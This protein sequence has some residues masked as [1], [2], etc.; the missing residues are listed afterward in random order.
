MEIAATTDGFFYDATVPQVTLCPTTCTTAENNLTANIQVTYSCD[1]SCSSQSAEAVSGPLDVLFLMDRTSGMA[2]DL[3]D[4]SGNDVGVTA[5]SAAETA[6][7]NFVRDPDV[8]GL[9]VGLSYYPIVSDC[10][11]CEYGSLSF[12]I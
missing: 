11:T 12:G 7:R 5:W 6:V 4:S 10:Y 9:E 1:S 8:A 3:T 2:N